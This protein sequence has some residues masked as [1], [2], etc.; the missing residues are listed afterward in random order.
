MRSRARQLG[1]IWVYVFQ[2]RRRRW[3]LV[4]RAWN[5]RGRLCGFTL[6]WVRGGIAVMWLPPGRP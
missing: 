1:P 4:G 6:C 5:H 3:L 2:P